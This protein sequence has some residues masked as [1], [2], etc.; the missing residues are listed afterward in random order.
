MSLS[1]RLGLIM[2]VYVYVCGRVHAIMSEQ[3]ITLQLQFFTLI[4]FHLIQ[5]IHY[6]SYLI[7]L[8]VVKTPEIEFW[9]Y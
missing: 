8:Y 7:I 6:P 4:K 3:N 5:K 2:C 1:T 9:T